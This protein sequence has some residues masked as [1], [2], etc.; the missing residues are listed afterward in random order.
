MHPIRRRLGRLLALVAAVVLAHGLVAIA[1]AQKPAAGLPKAPQPGTGR[2]AQPA[3]SPLAGFDA[4]V[5]R[6]MADWK[7]PGVAIAIVRDGQV[8]LS[9][10]YGLRDVANRLPVTSKTIFPI[11]SITKSFTVATLATLAGEGKIDWDKPVRDFL[12]EFRLADD[13][14]TARVTVRDLVTH[15]TGLP[16]H[17]AT[18]YHVEMPRADIVALLR[19]LEPSRDLRQSFQ[20][21]NLMF[22]TAGY[23]AGRLAGS[24]WEDAVRAR[25]FAPLGMT[26]SNFSVDESKRSSDWAHA[27]QKDDAEA[28]HEVPLLKADDVGPAGSINSTLEDM[29]QYLRMYLDGGQ[30]GGKPVLARTDVSQMMS[31]QMI[32]PS[33]GIDPEL[34]FNHYGMGLFVTSYRGHTL[35]HHG[36]NLDGFSLLISFLPGAKA[37]AVVLTNMDSTSL[38]EVL[39]Y[40]ICDR[41]LGLEPVDWNGRLMARYLAGKKAEADATAKNY[42]PRITGTRPAHA[43]DEYVGEY[44]HPAYG[45]IVVSRAAKETDLAIAYHGFTST[46]VHWHFEQW[47]VPPDALDRLERTDLAFNTDWQGHVRSVSVPMEPA[48]KDIEFIRQ[49]DRRMRE[50]GFLEPLVG[51]YRLGSVTLVVALRH[52]N[53]L[54]YTTPAGA[55]YRLEPLQGLTFAISGMSGGSIDFKKDASGAII[56]FALTTPGGTSVATRVK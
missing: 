44:R 10:G 37:G 55:V 41:L 4:D 26:S 35:V 11:A 43:M 3:S 23:L 15:R 13:V 6:M 24:T 20:Y 30:H 52:D 12:P 40:N 34:G 33:S 42:V 56:E 14:L 46:A 1:L 7:V 19:H 25:V 47:K 8:I 53:V 16:R 45:A 28:V 17:D 27:Y 51:T 32:I 49:P 2:Q 22:L 31:P 36:G 50:R 9:K 39:T 21:N 18:W 29:T 48:V 54:T 5:A 38:R